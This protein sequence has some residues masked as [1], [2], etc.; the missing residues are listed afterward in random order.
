MKW[1]E[2]RREEKKREMKY[3]PRMKSSILHLRLGGVYS[4]A[5]KGANT[6][7]YTIEVP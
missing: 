3:L 4:D 6:F 2:K 1:D 7:E 5:S